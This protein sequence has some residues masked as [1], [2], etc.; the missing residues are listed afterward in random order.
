MITA[1]ILNNDVSKIKTNDLYSS[2]KTGL[3]ITILSLSSSSAREKG[4]IN[5]S[6]TLNVGCV[7]L[8]D[9]H[10]QWQVISSTNYT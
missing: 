6:T 9:L 1:I 5:N 2:N 10:S 4:T 8:A 3:W 7:I